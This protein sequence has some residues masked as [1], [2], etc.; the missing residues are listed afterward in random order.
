MQT[1]KKLTTVL[2]AT[3]IGA[4]LGAALGYGPLLR[5]KSDGVLKVGLDTAEYKRVT[6]LAMDSRTLRTFATWSPPSDF[7]K[8]GVDKLIREMATQNW[9]TPIPRVSKVDERDLP[10][11]LLQQERANL[12]SQG[13]ALRVY[14]G[15][16]LSYTAATANEAVNG[17]TWLGAYFKDTATLE[18]L[19]QLVSDWTAETAQFSERAVETRL[20]YQFDIEQAQARADAFKK[21]VREYPEAARGDVSQVIDVR[22][23]N[24]KFMSPM[25]QLIGAQA[26]VIGVREHLQ[27]LDRQIDQQAL[28][29]KVVA[30]AQVAVSA[31][32]G[33]G[34][35]LNK[36][37]A[38]I[39]SFD[40]EQISGAQRQKL[41][42]L[43][44]QVAAVA[45]RFQSSSRFL[46][47][48][49]LPSSPER[50][51]PNVLTAFLAAFAA[52]VTAA[53]LWRES[54]NAFLAGR[55]ETA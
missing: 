7:S 5:Y 40:K 31:A 53:F 27:Q 12:A 6:E 39:S 34:D 55:A 50:P 35:A 18:A 32:H 42:S 41:S 26:E 30:Q 3:I 20:R 36:L 45:S 2:V 15:V 37:N 23:D 21:I 19:R 47:R 8:L 10:D 43:A 16:E 52:F 17:A 9:V 1:N 25:A 38:V 29:K 13:D 48:P 14:L 24:E 44:V 4:G 49:T 22:K 33:G 46:A 11:L 28:M 54:L 51:S